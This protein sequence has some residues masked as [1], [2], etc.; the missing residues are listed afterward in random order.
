[1]AVSAG[2]VSAEGGA[3]GAAEAGAEGT[4]PLVPIPVAVSPVAKECGWGRGSGRGQCRGCGRLCVA[5]MLALW[6]FGFAFTLLR[7]VV[8]ASGLVLLLVAA[9]DG[10]G[11]VLALLPAPEPAAFVGLV[12]ATLA[13][14]LLCDM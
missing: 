2:V 8:T 3:D 10:G 13:T 6:G 1:V 14:L 11:R 7:L 12:L 4:C 5:L 9:L